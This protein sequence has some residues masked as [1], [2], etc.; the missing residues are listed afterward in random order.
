[1][2]EADQRPWICTMRNFFS[3]WPETQEV[4]LV[5]YSERKGYKHEIVR[6]YRYGE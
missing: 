3:S 6:L 4:N 5:I 1:M 2:T